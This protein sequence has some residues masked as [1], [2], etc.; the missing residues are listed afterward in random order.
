MES[1]LD[2]VADPVHFLVTTSSDL[3][4]GC[5]HGWFAVGDAGVLRFNLLWQCHRG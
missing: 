3:A 5:R 1:P 4:G 2:Q